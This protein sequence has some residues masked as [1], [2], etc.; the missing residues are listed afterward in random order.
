MG[1]NGAGKTTLT[2]LLL[3]LYDVDSG[4]ISVNGRPISSYR[5]DTLR[6]KIGIVFQNSMLY[7]LTVRENMTA[8]TDADDNQLKKSLED[9][10]LN[11]NLNTQVTREF[12]QNGSVLSGGDSQRLCLTRLM[13]SDFGL[14]ILDEPSSAL[15]PIAEYNIAKLVF[16]SSPTTTI[17]IAHRLSTVVDA[18]MIYLLSNGS[19]IE[20][21]THA[22]LMEKCGK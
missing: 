8:Y 6:D 17:M 4:I 18:D 21:G 22:Q 14:I 10:G 7:A 13:H 2:K 16:N 15:D 1:E 5:I 3:R 19:I 9:V 12:D 11:L 20:S